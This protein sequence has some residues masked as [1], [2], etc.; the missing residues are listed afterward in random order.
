VYVGS[1]RLDLLLGEVR[2]LK[3]KRAVVRPIVAELRRRFEVSVAECG[4]LDLYR[5]CEVGVAVAGADAAHCRALLA[6]CEN[7]VAKRPEVELLSVRTRIW[8]DEDVD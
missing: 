2:S 6:S 8:H 7:L 4:H 1:L 3:Q 5:R